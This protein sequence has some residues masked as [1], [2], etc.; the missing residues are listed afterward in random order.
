MAVPSP[1]LSALNGFGSKRI[2]SCYLATK[3]EGILVLT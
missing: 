2:V 3:E 1:I